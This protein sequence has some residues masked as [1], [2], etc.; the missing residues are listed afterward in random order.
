MLTQHHFLV[1]GGAG[2]IGS[3]LV[4]DLELE[5]NSKVTVL[6]DFSAGDFRNLLNF[7][8]DVIAWDIR[9]AGWHEKVGEVDAVFHEAA[10]TDASE[11]DQREM[12]DV[13]VNGFRNVLDFAVKR[14]IKRVVFASSAEVYGNGPLPMK[15]KQYLAPENIY[16][17]S[18]AV[19]ENVAAEYALTHPYMTIVGLRYFSVYGPGE[20]YKGKNASLIHRIY[21]DIGA[22][23]PPS[24]PGDGSRKIDFV[25]I[26]DVIR[27]NMLAMEAKDSCTCNLA[28][29]RPETLKRVVGYVNAAL[30]KNV[31]PVYTGNHLP[32]VQRET[33]ADITCAKEK[34]N[35]APQ[36]DTERG[37]SDY[38]KNYLE[39]R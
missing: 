22:G 13:N 6:D 37:V 18:K 33:E 38:I 34:I 9:D 25:Y 1:T 5:H 32:R 24:L 8:G 15:E 28:S 36:W 12:M 39:K 27:G 23:K 17:F 30:G 2:F 35:F 19:M 4:K 26:K 31:E 3:G 11:E 29:G 21:R 7:K 16:G 20:F 14:G 10:I